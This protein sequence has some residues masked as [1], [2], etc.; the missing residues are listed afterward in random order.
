MRRM[1]DLERA[2]F[3]SAVGP[4]FA[5]YRADK[6]PT[7]IEEDVDRAIRDAKLLAEKARDEVK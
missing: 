5:A 1:K 2:V 3:L 4:L 7:K 6:F